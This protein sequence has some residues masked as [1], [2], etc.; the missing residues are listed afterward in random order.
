MGLDGRSK[1][2]GT[3]NFETEADA[4]KAIQVSDL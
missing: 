2:W 3:V 4:D 1:G